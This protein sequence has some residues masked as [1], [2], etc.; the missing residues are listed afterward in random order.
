V[1]WRPSAHPK[2]QKVCAFGTPVLFRPLL[3]RLPIIGELEL[4]GSDQV[5]Q[6]SQALC[7]CSL[8]RRLLMSRELEILEELERLGSDLVLQGSKP[9]YGAGLGGPCGGLMPRMQHFAGAAGTPI[10][11]AQLALSVEFSCSRASTCWSREADK[12]RQAS[13]RDWQLA[14]KLP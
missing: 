1:T 13:G 3:R 10:S 5:P 8:F 9:D 2:W 6:L 12:V 4:L 11:Q 14:G 7:I